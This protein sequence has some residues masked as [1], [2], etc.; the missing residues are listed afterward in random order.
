MP[1]FS[2]KPRALPSGEATGNPSQSKLHLR[3]PE[4]ARVLVHLDHAACFIVKVNQGI[5]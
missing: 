5:V 3:F 4:L 2:P 1:E